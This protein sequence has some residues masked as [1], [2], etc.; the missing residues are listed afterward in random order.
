MLLDILRVLLQLL[1]CGG[2]RR[3]NDSRCELVLGCCESCQSASSHLWHTVK[4]VIRRESWRCL[5]DDGSIL[6]LLLLFTSTVF[7]VARLFA[8]LRG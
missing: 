5:D 2:R 7:V 6:L 1:L 4:P 3:W 8:L